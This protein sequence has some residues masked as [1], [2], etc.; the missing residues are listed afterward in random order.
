MA[1]TEKMCSRRWKG[2]VRQVVVVAL[3]ISGLLLIVGAT[4]QAEPTMSRDEQIDLAMASLEDHDLLRLRVIPPMRKGPSL[5][6]PYKQQ[7]PKAQKDFRPPKPAPAPAPA[8][9]GGG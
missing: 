7:P 3:A 2:L 1:M 8:P 6:P 5:T 9:G 4:A